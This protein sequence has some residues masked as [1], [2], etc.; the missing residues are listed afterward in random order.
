MRT[1]RLSG[2]PASTTAERGGKGTAS[3]VS[4]RISP[5]AAHAQHHERCQAQKT[6]RGRED[7][8]EDDRLAA[9]ARRCRRRLRGRPAAGWS[10][11]V[12]SPHGPTS[13]A[14]VVDDHCCRKRTAAG[15]ARPDDQPCRTR[16]TFLDRPQTASIGPQQG[17]S[18]GGLLLFLTPSSHLNTPV[19]RF[20]DSPAREGRH[21]RKG[22]WHELGLRFNRY[23]RQLRRRPCSDRRDDKLR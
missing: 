7:D 4:G 16:A 17:P 23:R 22:R 11:R 14:S 1:S 2:Q 21:C 5:R 13:A 9:S 15:P 19:S 10:A 6:N 8:E 12:P 18:E 20:E 3:H